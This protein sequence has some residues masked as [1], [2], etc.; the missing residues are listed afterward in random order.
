MG[1]C[2]GKPPRKFND[3]KHKY[4]D[5]SPVES[6]LDLPELKVDG[7]SKTKPGLRAARSYEHATL[8]STRDLT[9]LVPGAI[10]A[11]LSLTEDQI[12][13]GGLSASHENHIVYVLDKACNDVRRGVN[14]NFRGKSS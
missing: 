6:P 13:I 9:S 2:G 10:C 4:A 7:Q 3:S 11:S 8:D 12:L 14:H 5:G 1:I